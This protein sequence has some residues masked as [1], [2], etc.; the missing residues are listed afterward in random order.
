MLG[1]LRME[2]KVD[3]DETYVESCYWIQSDDYLWCDRVQKTR[4]VQNGHKNL[5]VFDE[6]HIFC[7]S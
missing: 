5:K 4:T 3:V 7:P 6:E 2:I 1:I